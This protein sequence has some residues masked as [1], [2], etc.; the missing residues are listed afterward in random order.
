MGTRCR[1]NEFRSLADYANSVGIKKFDTAPLYGKGL[2]QVFIRKLL[3]ETNREIEI[4]T[5]IGRVPIFNFKTLAAWVLNAKFDPLLTKNF[6][7]GEQG[8]SLDNPDFIA[9]LRNTLNSFPAGFISTVFLHSPE[10]SVEIH[11]DIVRLENLLGHRIKIGVSEPDNA[12]LD[13]LL[14]IDDAPTIQIRFDDLKPIHNQCEHVVLNGLNRYAKY[15]DVSVFDL[16]SKALEILPDSRVDFNFS[17]HSEKLI[18]EVVSS[19]FKICNT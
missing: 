3:V 7:Y 19:Y 12:Q 16:M 15:H 17:F 4:Y 1:F 11:E 10:P 2:A 8:Y 9:K 5:K 6:S 14:G 13:A 18:D